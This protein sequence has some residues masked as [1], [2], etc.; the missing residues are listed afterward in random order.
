VFA[1]CSELNRPTRGEGEGPELRMV[2]KWCCIFMF[3]TGEVY[4]N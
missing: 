3:G 4:W 2:I 1:L